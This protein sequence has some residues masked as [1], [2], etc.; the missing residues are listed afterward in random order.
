[1]KRIVQEL[2]NRPYSRFFDTAIDQYLTSP[3][4]PECVLK[5]QVLQG[6]R[7]GGTVASGLKGGI[8][9]VQSAG[10]AEKV[11]AQMMRGGLKTAQV[12]GSG[13]I[14]EELH[15]AERIPFENGWY[16]SITLDREN[17]TPAVLI[18]KNKGSVANANPDHVFHFSF[19]DGI[20]AEVMA[21]IS[22]AIDI[23][24][25]ESE[26]LETIL[27]CLYDLF[28]SKDVT[29]LE[30]DSLAQLANREFSSLDVKMTVDTASVKRQK[31]LYAL[32]D[33]KHEVQEEVEAEKHGLV[34]VKMDGN[35][36]TVVNGAGLAMATNDVIAYHGGSSANFLD[37]GGQATKE[38]MMKAFEIVLSD[39][40]VKAILVNIYGG[41]SIHVDGISFSTFHAQ[42]VFQGSFDAT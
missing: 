32:R 39:S 12:P 19:K 6:N 28:K 7:L 5:S 20:T 16:L 25:G 17:N 13:A 15:V 4:G 8:Q 37:A 14:V 31:D 23:P 35:I 38:T 9:F 33:P 27:T 10:Q 22:R 18:S 36:G 3:E 30:I 42:R 21:D 1:M 24:H 2:G 29:K 41:E 11:A 26:G 40:R 34:Y